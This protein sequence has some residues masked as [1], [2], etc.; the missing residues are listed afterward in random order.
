MPIGTGLSAQFGFAEESVW[1]TRVAPSRFVDFN[2]ESLELSFDYIQS[3]GLRAGARLP[4][5]S[6]QVRTTKNVSGE[7]ELDVPSKGYGLLLKHMLGS[8]T[9][10]TP[11]G[12]TT[13]RVHRAQFGALDGKSLSIQVG[14]P[15]TNT[16]VYPFD[17][18]G[19]KIASWELT[20]DVND[21]LKATHTIDGTDERTDQTLATATYAT[22]A[23]SLNYV[24]GLVTLGGTPTI[25]GTAVVSL[26]GGTATDVSS[27]TL[28]C[29]NSL[30]TERYFI[31]QNAN[32]KE[33]L[34]AGLG[35]L[36]GSWDL[37]F[38]DMT[39]YNR[40]T[41]GTNISALFKWEGATIEGSFKYGL[42]ILLAGGVRIEGETPKVGGPDILTFTQNFTVFDD[43]TNAPI[44]IDYVTTDTAP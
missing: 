5:G 31:R 32:K 3:N 17:Y 13:T 38:T 16:T 14:K 15:A 12:G 39:A 30:A 8:V 27:V 23:E 26:S 42:Y 9:T 10:F 21:F 25:S 4:F 6:R 43:G 20:N 28:S 11:S 18:L 7:F 36:T 33:Q 35:G 2:S 37:E 41:A 24:G 44:T 22:A 29:D 40:F 34:Q 1:G 19:C